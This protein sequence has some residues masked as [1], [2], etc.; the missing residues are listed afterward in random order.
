MEC[1]PCASCWGY[2]SKADKVD[3]VFDL[4]K[5]VLGER[6]NIN[7]FTKKHSFRL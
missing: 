3:K 4:M 7:K 5:S 6:K 2:N 1:S